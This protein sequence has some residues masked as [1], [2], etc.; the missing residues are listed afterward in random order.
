MN[1]IIKIN[2]SDK[3]YIEDFDYDYYHFGISDITHNM[4]KY[5]ICN[6]T[7]DNI[8]LYGFFNRDASAS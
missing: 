1:N 4:L 2:S 7:Y 3:A 8:Y 6:Y 5:V